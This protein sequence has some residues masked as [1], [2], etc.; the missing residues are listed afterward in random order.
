MVRI[1][2]RAVQEDDSPQTQAPQVR[3]RRSEQSLALQ[4]IGPSLKTLSEIAGSDKGGGE[5]RL[6]RRAQGERNIAG[7]GRTTLK[8]GSQRY[9]AE[10]HRGEFGR[11][12]GVG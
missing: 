11:R 1:G 9:Y 12:D 6:G 10:G 5:I 2:T 3:W 7:R 8:A 4:R